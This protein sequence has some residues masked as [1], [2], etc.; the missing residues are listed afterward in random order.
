[1][2]KRITVIIVILVFLTGC[3]VIGKALSDPPATKGGTVSRG[4]TMNQVV[5]EWGNPYRINRSVGSW[6]VNEQWVYVS[7]RYSG[8][9]PRFYLYFKNGELTSWQDMRR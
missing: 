1:M 9:H 4:M 2:M 7:R 8:N 6:G 3:S 5:A